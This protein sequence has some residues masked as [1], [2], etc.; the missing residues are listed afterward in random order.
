MTLAGQ[1][2]ASAS[3]HVFELLDGPTSVAHEIEFRREMFHESP[4][5]RGDFAAGG[6]SIGRHQ[7]T[8]GQQIHFPVSKSIFQV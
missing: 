2:T 1:R 4:R 3:A 5:Q 8:I 6:T 7:Q